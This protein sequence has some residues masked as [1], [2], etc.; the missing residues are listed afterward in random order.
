MK[1][2]TYIRTLALMAIFAFAACGGEDYTDDPIF[3]QDVKTEL[4]D[5]SELPE[6]LA[7]YINYLEY[8]PEGQDLPTEP[9]GIYRFEWDGKTF[10]PKFRSTLV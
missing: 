6:W 9:S 7:D 2:Y 10:Y 4:V 3:D 8:V 1:Q 5:K